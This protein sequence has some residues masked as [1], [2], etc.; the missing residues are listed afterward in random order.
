MK[1][2]DIKLHEVSKHNQR[3]K[4]KTLL[5]WKHEAESIEKAIAHA[6]KTMET[7][8]DDYPF[9]ICYSVNEL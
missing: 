8:K 3:L 9:R 2:F 5:N 1:N 4:R 7:V 6:K